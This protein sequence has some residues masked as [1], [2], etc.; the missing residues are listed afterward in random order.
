MT[1]ATEIG[2]RQDNNLCCCET[3]MGFR[4]FYNLDLNISQ[5]WQW[6][7]RCQWVL[8]VMMVMVMRKTMGSAASASNMR[9]CLLI[10][11]PIR[12]L[13]CGTNTGLSIMQ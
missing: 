4:D 10:C 2:F 12:L 6:Q 13:I 11:L 7:W 8:G 1:R 3:R 5:Q 9:I